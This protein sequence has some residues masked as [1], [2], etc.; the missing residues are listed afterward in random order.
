MEKRIT[1]KELNTLAQKAESAMK[2]YASAWVKYN[3][4]PEP[5]GMV[6]LLNTDTNEMCIHTTSKG[7]DQ[8]R[9]LI[10]FPTKQF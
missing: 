7:T 2:E 5:N 3:N 6:Y 4:V 8:L 10:D 9:G 1:S